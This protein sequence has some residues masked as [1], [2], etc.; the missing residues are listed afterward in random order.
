MFF[1]EYWKKLSI[2]S[3]AVVMLKSQCTALTRT[4]L[5]A[6]TLRLDRLQR[7]LLLSAAP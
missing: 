4:S 6:V 1:D 2:L 5:Q 7:A 3:T